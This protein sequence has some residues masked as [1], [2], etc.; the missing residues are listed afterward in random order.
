MFWDT[1]FNFTEAPISQS[2]AWLHN[3]TPW[4]LVDTSSSVVAGGAA[5]G[6]QTGTG[7]FD[8]SY[9]YLAGVWGANQGGQVIVHLDGAISHASTHEIEILLRV[10]DSSTQVTA[11]ECNLAYDGSYAEIVR[12]NGPLGNFTYVAPQGSGGP[13][14]GVV[15]TGG[16]FSAHIIGNTITSFYNGVQLNTATDNVLTAGNPGIGFFRNNP[17]GHFDGDYC[18]THVR[19]YDAM[20]LPVARLSAIILP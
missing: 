1:S 9:A 15:A 7:Q 2:G 4:S 6:T 18:I 17:T 10:Q 14:P 11:Y 13:G 5:Y 3:A 12:W 19:A 20:P 16:I 8:D